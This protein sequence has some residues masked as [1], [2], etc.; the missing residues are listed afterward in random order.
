MDATYLIAG[1]VALLLLV[2]LVASLLKPEWF[3]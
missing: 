3:G 1:A 2:Y